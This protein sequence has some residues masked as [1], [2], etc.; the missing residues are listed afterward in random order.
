MTQ[1]KNLLLRALKKNYHWRLKA[2]PITEDHYEDPITEDPH[3][4]PIPE[5]PKEGLITV[6]PKENPKKTLNDFCVAKNS[7]FWKWFMI[8]WVMGINIHMK[9]LVLVDLI[10]LL[11]VT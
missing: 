3:D 4:R 9:L 5:K 11:L 8:E 10:F 2:D 6:K 1:Q 7:S